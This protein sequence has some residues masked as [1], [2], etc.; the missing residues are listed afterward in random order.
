M[1]GMG[2]GRGLGPSGAGGRSFDCATFSFETHIHSPQP[3]N[4]GSISVGEILEVVLAIMDGIQVVQIRK[5]DGTVVGGLVE[6]GPRIRECLEAGYIYTATVRD[7]QGA[8][9]RIFVQSQGK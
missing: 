3:Q 1:S 4:I 7:I 8:A 6:K 5:S 2:S 9:I